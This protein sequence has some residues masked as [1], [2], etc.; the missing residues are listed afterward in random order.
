MTSSGQAPLKFKLLAKCSVTK[1][2]VGVINLLH[3]DVSTP[4]FMPVGTKVSFGA[5]LRAPQL[6]ILTNFDAFH[7]GTMKGLL[8]QQLY[9]LNCEI[10]L[11]NTYHLGLKPVSTS[12][13]LA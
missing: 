6:I 9:A 8:Q 2:R 10:M 5:P 11:S 13:S 12:G 3:S 4:V 7:Q 1:A